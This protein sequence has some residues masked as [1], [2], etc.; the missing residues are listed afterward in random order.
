MQ[1]HPISF[2]GNGSEYFQ[3]WVSNLVMSIMTLGCYSPWAKVRRIRYFYQNT[4]LANAN[5]DYHGN[6]VSILK[7]RLVALGLF[8]LYSLQLIF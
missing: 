1:K 6:P 3:I 7:G 8:I 4:H 2:T 5:F